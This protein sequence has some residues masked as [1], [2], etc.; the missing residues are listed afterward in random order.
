MIK[1]KYNGKGGLKNT[2]RNKIRRILKQLKIAGGK[3]IELLK[4]SLEVWRSK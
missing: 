4:S 3:A 1:S 2:P